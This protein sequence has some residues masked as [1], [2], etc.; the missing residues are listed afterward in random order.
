MFAFLLSLSFSAVHILVELSL[1]DLSGAFVYQFHD[2]QPL[3]FSVPGP[4]KVLF[5]IYGVFFNLF[6]L[7]EHFILFFMPRFSVVKRIFIVEC[8]EANAF[9]LFACTIVERNADLNRLAVNLSLSLCFAAN[10]RSFVIWTS[11]L[12]LF[13]LWCWLLITCHCSWTLLCSWGAWKCRG[14]SLNRWKVLK[15]EILK[16][17]CSSVWSSTQMNFLFKLEASRNFSGHSTSK[18]TATQLRL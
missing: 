17:V 12:T 9:F 4:R 6:L 2:R 14:S 7:T 8:F 10:V 5:L 1:W 3:G 15:L 11:M 16:K 13:R 18:N